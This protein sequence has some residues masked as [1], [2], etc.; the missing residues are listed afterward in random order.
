MVPEALRTGVRIFALVPAAYYAFASEAARHFF[1]RSAL[2]QIVNDLANFTPA[3]SVLKPVRGLDR[4]SL[5][6][7]TSFCRQDYPAYE[8][9]FAVADASDA[10]IPIIRQLADDYSRPVHPVDCR[11][12]R[13]WR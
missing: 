11:C 2:D 8:I 12:A 4:H 5:E 9:L 13:N 3:V 6:H 7:F 1:R 10:A